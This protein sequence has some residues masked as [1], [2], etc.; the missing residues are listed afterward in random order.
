VRLGLT[1]CSRRPCPVHSHSARKGKFHPDRPF[2]LSYTKFLLTAEPAQSFSV[3]LFV[4][5]ACFAF[6]CISVYNILYAITGRLI[7]HGPGW[8]GY[9]SSAMIR[10]EDEWAAETDKERRKQINPFNV[11]GRTALGPRGKMFRLS[12]WLRDSSI[13]ADEENGQVKGVNKKQ[14]G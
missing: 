1:V 12:R 7:D 8:S 10:Y 2:P 6:L 9:R 11:G 3:T 5:Y 13:W 14:V 4:T